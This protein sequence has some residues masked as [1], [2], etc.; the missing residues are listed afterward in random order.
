MRRGKLNGNEKTLR[1]IQEKT[2]AGAAENA[3]ELHPGRVRQGKKQPVGGETAQ[4]EKVSG[5]SETGT[6]QG[7]KQKPV[8]YGKANKIFTEDA[9]NKARE[10]LKAKLKQLSAGIDP[11]VI[12]AGITLAVYHVESGARKFTVFTAAML[13]DLG[14]G[15]KPYLKSF[16]LAI[17]NWPGMDTKGTPRLSR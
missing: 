12:Q 3:K 13:A 2:A 15:I 7:E 10:I 8:G 11:E 1:Q 16:Y 5:S 6:G 9:A 17:H 14:E 4:G